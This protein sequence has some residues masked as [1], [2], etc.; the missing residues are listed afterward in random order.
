MDIKDVMDI[1][2][3]ND[4][5]GIFE[6]GYFYLEYIFGLFNIVVDKYEFD[7]SEII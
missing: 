6:D 5:F 7:D 3:D 4:D 2:L 1:V